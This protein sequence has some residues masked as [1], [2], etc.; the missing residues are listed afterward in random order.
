MEQFIT[1]V[2]ADYAYSPYI[3]YGAI[4]LFMLLSA[5]G[6]PL[7]EELVLISAGFIGHMALNPDLYPPPYPGAQSV[8]V[9]VLATVAFFAVMGSDYL[10]YAIGRALGP[11][12]FKMKWFNKLVS[13]EALERVQRWMRKYGYWTVF[14]FRFTPGVRFPGHLTCGAVGLSRWRFLAVDTIAAGFSVPTQVLLVA[15]YGQYILQYLTKFKTYL[16]STL[17]AA[18][19][20]F[21]LYR[22]Y[23]SKFSSVAAK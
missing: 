19:V 23:K 11:K 16:F 15:F 20:L 7:P 8:N 22:L 5:F 6:M 17:G 10:I 2:F 13:P 12:L 4:C 1:Q 18:I 9:Y 3:V 14:I 21:L